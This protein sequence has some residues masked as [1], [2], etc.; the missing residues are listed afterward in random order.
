MVLCFMQ[1]GDNVGMNIKQV[2][3]NRLKKGM[4]LTQPGSF[5]T[6]NHFD[7]S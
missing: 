6:T 7:V 2:K 5:E 1:A 4:I 3:A